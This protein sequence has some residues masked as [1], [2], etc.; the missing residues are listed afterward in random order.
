MF[1]MSETLLEN[2]LAV[3]PLLACYDLLRTKP[4]RKRSNTRSCENKLAIEA[5]TVLAFVLVLDL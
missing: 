2:S 3:A 5:A 4:P 1:S